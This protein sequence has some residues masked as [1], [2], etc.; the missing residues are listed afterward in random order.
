MHF[1]LR[2]GENP[3]KKKKKKKKKYVV[4]RLRCVYILP[5]SILCASF[6]A[7][8]REGFADVDYQSP[9]RRLPAA[10]V[11]SSSSGMES[12]EDCLSWSGSAG[13][14]DDDDDDKRRAREGERGVLLLPFSHAF[15]AFITTNPLPLL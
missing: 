3:K 4:T 7:V 2:N 5:G 8:I 14:D 11:S 6:Q 13:D 15:V 10:A 1:R 12:S 9:L